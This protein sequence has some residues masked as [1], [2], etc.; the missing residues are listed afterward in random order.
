MEE[1]LFHNQVY[2]ITFLFSLLVVWVHSF[3]AELYLGATQAAA[4]VKRL[5]WILGEG[6]GQISVPGFFMV[7]SYLFY[8]RFNW[9]RLLP[10]WKSRIRSILVP[11]LIWNFLYY[12]GYVAAT[13]IP[14][15]SGLIGKPPVPVTI[16][17]SVDALVNYAYNPVFWYLYQLILLIA[18]APVVYP[19]MKRTLTGAAALGVIAFALWHGWDFPHLNMDALFYTCGAAYISLHRDGWGRFAESLPP[20]GGRRVLC[21]GAAVLLLALVLFLSRPMAPLYARPLSAVLKRI[22][23]VC[24]VWFLLSGLPLPMARDWMKHNFFL[25]AIHFAWVRLFN[26]AGAILLP[27]VPASALSMF[28]LMPLFMVIISSL[29]RKC[30]QS[31]VPGVYRVLSGNR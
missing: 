28:L 9:S 14:A 1:K 10:K 26:K 24:A 19:V 21:W 2:W 20:R 13:R 22:W 25:Y 18:L 12:A 17:Q 3:N 7:S 29:L 15:I 30:L 23:G 8:R 27:P 11:Y 4:G 5:E 31:V 16:M 6:L